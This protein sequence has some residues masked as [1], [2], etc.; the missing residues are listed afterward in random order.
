MILKSFSIKKN[1]IV[2]TS[3]V[4]SP[5]FLNFADNYVGYRTYI[6]KFNNKTRPVHKNLKLT[7]EKYGNESTKLV[8]VDEI[9]TKIEFSMKCIYRLQ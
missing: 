7:E 8:V 6:F 5:Q 9:V 4:N 3:R 1:K 2:L